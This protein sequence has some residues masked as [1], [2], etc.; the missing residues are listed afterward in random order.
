MG[1]DEVFLGMAS[2]SMSNFYSMEEGF[3]RSQPTGA[4]IL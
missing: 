2:K 1:E 3:L 4:I